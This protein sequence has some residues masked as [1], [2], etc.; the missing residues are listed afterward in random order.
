MASELNVRP[1]VGNQSVTDP[2]QQGRTGTESFG[3]RLR[4]LRVTRRLS[5]MQ[6]ASALS[7]SV[8]AI[9]AWEKDRARPRHGRV[10]ALG[11]V[12]GVSTAELLGSDGREFS[13]DMLAESRAHIARVVGTTPDKVRILIEF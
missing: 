10:E 1:R 9:S 4:R 7:V 8:P 5:Q 3:T 11:N 2:L 6:L 13:P 12:L